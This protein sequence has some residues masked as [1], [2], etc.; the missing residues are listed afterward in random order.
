MIDC[1]FLAQLK[2]VCDRIFRDERL[3]ALEIR[4]LT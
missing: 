3:W 1:R 2:N 4:V